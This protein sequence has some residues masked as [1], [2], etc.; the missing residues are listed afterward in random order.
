MKQSMAYQAATARKGLPIGRKVAGLIGGALALGYA[1]YHG[2]MWPELMPG[3]FANEWLIAA[4]LQPWHVY[5]GTIALLAF[6]AAVLLWGNQRRPHGLL[7]CFGWYALAVAVVG[8]LMPAL[9][10]VLAERPDGTAHDQ[11]TGNAYLVARFSRPGPTGDH[12]LVFIAQQ[13]IADL[14]YYRA[15]ADDIHKLSQDGYP[16][17][18]ELTDANEARPS[19]AAKF[20]GIWY[21]EQ[22]RPRMRLDVPHQ[23]VQWSAVTDGERWMNVD[24]HRT[25]PRIQALAS[26]AS[27]KEWCHAMHKARDAYLL[28]RIEAETQQKGRLAVIYGIQH[29]YNLRPRLIDAGWREVEPAQ[30][31]P[32]G[33]KAPELPTEYCSDN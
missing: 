20:N 4:G 2:R 26:I 9:D 11:M 18:Y 6:I 24:L 27:D 14:P 1:A 29:F 8:L 7:L 33:R 25:H 15:L 3:V 16:F 28:E 31:R 17:A 19:L 10:Y 13:H 22:Y 30:L 12:M 32:T 5:F 21:E 23:P